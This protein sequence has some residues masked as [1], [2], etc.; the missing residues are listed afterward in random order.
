MIASEISMVHDFGE[1]VSEIEFNRDD[2]VRRTGRVDLRTINAS[3][4]F[5]ASFSASH[6]QA[7]LSNSVAINDRLRG[8]S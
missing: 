1:G 4:L 5:A 7:S 8:R 6:R 2:G 3:D